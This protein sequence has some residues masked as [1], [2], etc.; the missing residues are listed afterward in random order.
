MKLHYALCALFVALVS[1]CSD[2]GRSATEPGAM[3]PGDVGAA[4]AFDPQTT[5]ASAEGLCSWPTV[6]DP[7]VLNIAYPDEGATYWGTMTPMLRGSRVRIEGQYP[8]ARYFSFHVY[9]PLNRPVDSLTDFRILPRI[10]GSNA[11]RTAGAA[12]GADYVAYIVPEPKPENPEPNTIYAGSLSLPGSNALPANP[13][14]IV[15]YRIYLPE[16]DATGGVPLPRLSYE[17]ADG[18]VVPLSLSLCKPLPPEG[19]PPLL[20]EPIREA[21]FPG[22]ASPSRAPP[23]RVSRFYNL[24]ESL[25]VLLASQSGMEIPPNALTEDS[26]GGFLSNRDIAYVSALFRRSSG[27]LYVVR[28]RAPT[29]AR[30]PTDAPLGGAQ[31]RYWSL[32]VNE[33]ASQRFV[34]CAHDEQVPLDAAGFFTIV[35]S[36]PEDRP[37][38]AVAGNGMLWLPWGG[39]YPDSL[40]I[41]RHMLPNA[42]F[43]EAIQNI[44]YGTAPEDVMGEYFPRLAYCD[45]ATVEAAG[46]N[47]AAVFAACGS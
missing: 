38:N 36:D 45:R 44:P 5:E 37:A 2:G 15:L 23:P 13:L 17:L 40:L 24:F 47:P 18:S 21:S 6:S 42:G 30:Q 39:V 19:L 3:V 32:C 29:T 27:Q 16:V 8:Q 33:F 7:D 20:N 46:S 41:Y 31:L 11:F 43:G 1:G 9:D 12:P 34:A 25:R 28:A 14:P 35:V 26:S 4:A 10:A 22:N